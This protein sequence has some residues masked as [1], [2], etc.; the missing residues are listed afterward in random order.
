MHQD[1]HIQCHQPQEHPEQ[2]TDIVGGSQVATRK[3]EMFIAVLSPTDPTRDSQTEG[4]L[5]EPPFM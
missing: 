4:Q 2:D 3:M 5:T 1:C